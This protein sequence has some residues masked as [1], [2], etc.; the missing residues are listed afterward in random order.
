M[1]APLPQLRPNGHA[2]PPGQVFV[3][4]GLCQDPSFRLRGAAPGDFCL[5]HLGAS[6]FGSNPAEDPYFLLRR[7]FE[8]G[9]AI[10]AL[11]VDWEG[12]FTLLAND[13]E[14]AETVF[15]EVIEPN[16]PEEVQRQ[17]SADP[18][19]LELFADALRQN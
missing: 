11:R 6:E 19:N 13:D 12:V 16:Q 10:V 2:A 8:D 17:W 5:I 15:R 1:R 7:P 14:C 9:E 3:I 4:S 18:S